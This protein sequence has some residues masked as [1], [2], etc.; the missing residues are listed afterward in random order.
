MST[1]TESK[2][3]PHPTAESQPYWDS[4]AEGTLRLQRCASCGKFRHYPR[5]V[6][7]RCYS[8]QVEWIE[9]S[10]RGVVHSWT[11]AHHAF[12]PLVQ[13]RA[14]VYAGDR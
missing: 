4:A 1:V 10:G 9:A 2:P 3:V 11:V 6:C 8:L 12:H 14:A 13:G 7:D 5:L